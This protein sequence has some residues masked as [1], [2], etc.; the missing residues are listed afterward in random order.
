MAGL[1]SGL[2]RGLRTRAAS[3]NAWRAGPVFAQRG[4]F[5]TIDVLTVRSFNVEDLDLP[6][7][8]VPNDLTRPRQ[9]SSL[10][11]ELICHF[12]L[13]LVALA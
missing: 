5:R 9:S 2:Q 7:E 12:V 13:R 8:L 6:A 10:R 3:L 11:I 1:V 4:N